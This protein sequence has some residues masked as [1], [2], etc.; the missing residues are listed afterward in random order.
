MAVAALKDL[1]QLRRLFLDSDSGKGALTDASVEYLLG[2]TKLTRLWMRDTAL[3][4]K[5]LRRLFGLL[6]LKE[7]TISTSAIAETLT[8]ELRQQR[9]PGLNLYLTCQPSGK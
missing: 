1:K 2:M 6:E 3:T 9:P 7:L 8:A 4:E 5:G